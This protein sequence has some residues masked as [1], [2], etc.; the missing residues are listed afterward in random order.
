MTTYRDYTDE[1]IERRGETVFE[2]QVRPHLDEED[3]GKY[4]TIDVE[5]GAW[6]MGEDSLALADRL[7]ADHPEAALYT[8]RV[9]YPY[10]VRL[11]GRLAA[12]G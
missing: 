8:L 6:L 11:G 9:G 12:K 4:V 3:K 1:E 7:H 5:T 10:T 2:A